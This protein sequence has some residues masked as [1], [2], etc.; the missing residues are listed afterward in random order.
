MSKA[1]KMTAESLLILAEESGIDEQEAVFELLNAAACLCP[2]P[3]TLRDCVEGVIQ[4][5]TKKMQG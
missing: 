5:I 1:K 4:T 3:D 2:G